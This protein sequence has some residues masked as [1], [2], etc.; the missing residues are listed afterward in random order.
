[1]AKFKYLGTTVTNENWIYEE[2][3]S[4]LNSGNACCRSVQN[5]L[6]YR[7]LFKNVNI[8]IYEPVIFLVVL[9]ACGI[10]SLTLMAE[11]IEGI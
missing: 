9:Y 1:V 8:N 7:L 10:V 5:R 4:T 2:I 11:Y 6:Y 3:K